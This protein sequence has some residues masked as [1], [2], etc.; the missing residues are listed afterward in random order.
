MTMAKFGKKSW[1]PRLK[2]IVKRDT[3]SCHTCNRF[4]AIAVSSPPIGN[5]PRDRTQGNIPF[6]VVGVDYVALTKRKRER[7]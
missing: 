1:S 5:L 3:K 7:M 4:R 2:S 6:Q